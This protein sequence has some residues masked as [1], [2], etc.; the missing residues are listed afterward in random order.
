MAKNLGA[1]R[2]FFGGGRDVVIMFSIVQV[3][4]CI[5]ILSELKWYY[6]VISRLLI[7]I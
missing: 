7:F 2:F 4:L 1:Q 3:I 5:A 6:I